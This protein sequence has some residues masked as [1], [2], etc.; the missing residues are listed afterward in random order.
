MSRSIGR[1][2]A[3]ACLIAVR[4]LYVIFLYTDVTTNAVRRHIHTPVYISL[5]F[6]PCVNHHKHDKEILF[7]PLF[8]FY[9]FLLVH[10]LLD[11]KYL[12]VLKLLLG[13]SKVL[14]KLIFMHVQEYRI[15]GF[16]PGGG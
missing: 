4:S 6:S 10:L 14:L 15:A 7:P 16:F 2:L 13:L 1:P 3:G 11:S 9:H 12:H 5:H 8:C